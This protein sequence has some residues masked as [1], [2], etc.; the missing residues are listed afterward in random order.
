[1]KVPPTSTPSS[2]GRTIRGD[3]MLRAFCRYAA[4][5]TSSVSARCW[6]EGQ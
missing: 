4:I 6:C 1:V 5:A 2:T 3:K